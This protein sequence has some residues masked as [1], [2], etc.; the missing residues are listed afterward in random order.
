MP[1]DVLEIYLITGIH[2]PLAE[3]ILFLPTL[4]GA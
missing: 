1:Y 3:A 2:L 4:L